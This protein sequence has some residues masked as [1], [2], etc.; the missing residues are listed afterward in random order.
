ML[1]LGLQPPVKT[2]KSIT[3]SLDTFGIGHPDFHAAIGGLR[4]VVGR[5]QLRQLL[6]Y[7]IQLALQI[8]RVLLAARR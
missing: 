3:F 1:H 8:V 4:I 2:R 7:G 5:L 6:V